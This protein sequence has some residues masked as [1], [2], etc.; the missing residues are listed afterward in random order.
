[1]PRK[2]KEITDEDQRAA[3]GRQLADQT[4]LPEVVPSSWTQAFAFLDS[5]IT[6]DEWTVVLLD[7]ISWMGEKAPRLWLSLWKAAVAAAG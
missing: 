1:M 2:K 3:F 6:D 4:R 7:E 5:V